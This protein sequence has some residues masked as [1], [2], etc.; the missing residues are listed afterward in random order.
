[1]YTYVGSDSGVVEAR[2]SSVNSEFQRGHNRSHSSGTHS[3]T[4]IVSR[5]APQVPAQTA[6][7]ASTSA[8][9]VDIQRQFSAPP[10][11]GVVFDSLGLSEI[12][13]NL[14]QLTRQLDDT[15]SMSSSSNG[16]FAWCV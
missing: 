1:M 11:S 7:S 6:M 15:C 2:R 16:M 10:P 9:S 13:D 12:L 4:S 3:T 5:G 14:D 8:K